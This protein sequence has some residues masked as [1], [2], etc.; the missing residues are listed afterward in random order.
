[1]SWDRR[2]WDWEEDPKGAIAG[3]AQ[4][5]TLGARMQMVN[6]GVKRATCVPSGDRN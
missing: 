1:M 2:F 6:S 3:I 4:W 5:D